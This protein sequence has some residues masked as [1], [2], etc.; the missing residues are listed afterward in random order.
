MVQNLYVHGLFSPRLAQAAAYRGR[1][2]VRIN[3]PRRCLRLAEAV[4]DYCACFFFSVISQAF[5]AERRA[6]QWR[7][8]ELLYERAVNFV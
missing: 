8:N 3:A 7:E 2:S 6:L 1:E 4:N 5:A